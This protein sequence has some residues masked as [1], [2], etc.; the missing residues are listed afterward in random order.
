V[1]PHDPTDEIE[2]EIAFTS[3]VSWILSTV[4]ACPSITW[5]TRRVEIVVGEQENNGAIENN[6]AARFFGRNAADQSK[7]AVR[8]SANEMI[9]ELA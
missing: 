5:S 9:I 3:S 6:Q 8:N 4:S 1:L 7:P 2:L